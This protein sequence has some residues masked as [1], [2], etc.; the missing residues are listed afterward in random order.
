MICEFKYGIRQAS[1]VLRNSHLECRSYM[2]CT[3]FWWDVISQN[4]QWSA[5]VSSAGC[6]SS[7]GN[8]Q[9]YKVW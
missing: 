2:H 7:Q 5:Q 6:E 3:T 8:N 9:A 1:T 4:G